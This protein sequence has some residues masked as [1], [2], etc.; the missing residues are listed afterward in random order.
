MVEEV[1][2]AQG[3]EEAGMMAT[4]R[5]QTEDGADMGLSNGEGTDL[6]QVQEVDTGHRQEAT[7]ERE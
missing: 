7:G 6:H 4:D 3:P 2:V 1:I 5:H